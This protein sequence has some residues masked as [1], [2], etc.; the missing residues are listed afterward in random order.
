M[1]RYKGL[2]LDLRDDVA[3]DANSVLGLRCMYSRAERLG[4]KA[5][6]RAGGHVDPGFVP[7]AA[8]EPPNR[9]ASVPPPTPT[10]P[11]IEWID[12][13]EASAILIPWLHSMESRRPAPRS[14]QPPGALGSEVAPKPQQ[15]VGCAAHWPCVPPD[16]HLSS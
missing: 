2:Q 14:A 6:L 13:P 11:Q 10:A 7:K 4:S 5:M 16:D 1:R 8:S 12:T 3:T 9:E 15:W